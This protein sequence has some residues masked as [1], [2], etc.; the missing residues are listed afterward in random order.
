MP[1][2][3]A[4]TAADGVPK[5]FGA[6]VDF[7]GVSEPDDGARDGRK[8]VVGAIDDIGGIPEKPAAGAVARP[9][10]GFGALD[11]GGGT[12]VNPPAE[13]GDEAA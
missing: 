1:S 6:I 5:S 4:A 11:D 3:V 8:Y 12:P 9:L 13:A 7:D 2:K 10:P